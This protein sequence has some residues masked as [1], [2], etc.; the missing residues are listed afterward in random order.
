MSEELEPVAEEEDDPPFVLKKR[1]FDADL[2]FTSLIDVVF[3]L[4]IFFMVT[5][6]MRGT[7][8]I[9]VPR[10]KFGTGVADRQATVI[11]ILRNPATNYETAVI[12]LGDGRGPESEIE[13]VRAYVEEGV[14]ARRTQ[15]IIKAERDVPH[16]FVQQVAKQV[17][18]IEGIQFNIGVQDK[19]G[20]K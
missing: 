1:D 10:A 3:L 8:D 4:L 2:D 18:G 7:P 16:G 9:D 5:S 6:T 12:L 17:A 11:T 19:P 15:V 20:G 14:R 13:G